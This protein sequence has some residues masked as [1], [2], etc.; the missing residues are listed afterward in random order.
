[1]KRFLRIAANGWALLGWLLLA[2]IAAANSAAAGPGAYFPGLDDDEREDYA[3]WVAS[4]SSSYP[5]HAFAAA[6]PGDPDVG[7]AVFWNVDGST[8]SFAVA[9]RAEGWVGFGISEAGGML[10]SD[11]ALYEASASALTDRHVIEAHAEPLLDECQDWTLND[12]TV[13]GGWI[14]VEVSRS[15]DTGDKQDH[16]IK[17]DADFW[18]APTRI[19]AA[20]GDSSSISYH[21]SNKARSAV[22]IFG[23]SVDGKSELEALVSELESESDG[24]FDVREDNHEITNEETQYHSI[25]TRADELNVDLSQ[26]QGVVTSIGGEFYICC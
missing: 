18:T 24:Y 12:A 4:R 19:I 3:S 25:C 22:R 2:P 6:T 21:G 23:D 15:L 9:A 13:G 17:A 1:M 5:R 14:I 11:I 20:W 10:G 16:A 7:A 26:D 8:I